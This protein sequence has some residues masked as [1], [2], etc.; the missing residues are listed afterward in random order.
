MELAYHLCETSKD[1]CKSFWKNV[2]SSWVTRIRWNLPMAPGTGNPFGS[3]SGFLSLSHKWKCFSYCFHLSIKATI[4]DNIF[5]FMPI[6]IHALSRQSILPFKPGEPVMSCALRNGRFSNSRVWETFL[7]PQ[8][9][10]NVDDVPGCNTLSLCVFH[11]LEL[12]SSL[13]SMSSSSRMD[14]LFPNLW[15]GSLPTQINSR[16]HLHSFCTFVSPLP[17]TLTT[18]RE[19]PVQLYWT[20]GSRYKLLHHG[21]DIHPMWVKFHTATKH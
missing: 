10:H 18:T 16:I 7:Q 8:S 19:A 12:N 5:V 17:W 11:Q 13:Y 1:F 9:G 21:R 14:D 4:L 3:G 2:D 6:H 20:C 15:D